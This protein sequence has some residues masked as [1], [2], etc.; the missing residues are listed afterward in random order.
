MAR[1]CHTVEQIVSKLLTEM[2]SFAPEDR[3]G[4]RGLRFK[5]AGT[6]EKLISGAVPKV[7]HAVVS[8]TGLDALWIPIDRWFPVD[9]SRRAA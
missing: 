1:R 6:L 4:R 3:D 2:L 7:S 5:A 8:P 9:E